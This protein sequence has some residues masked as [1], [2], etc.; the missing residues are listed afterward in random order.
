M[1]VAP[2][3][4]VNHIHPQKAWHFSTKPWRL[5]NAGGHGSESEFF[6]A[7][8]RNRAERDEPDRD[9]DLVARIGETLASEKHRIFES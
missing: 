7:G 3:V 8:N 5:G 9:R 6:L 4:S 1:S 2:E